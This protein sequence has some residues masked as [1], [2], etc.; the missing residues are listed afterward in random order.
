MAAR[1]DTSSRTAWESRVVL[2]S[3]FAVVFGIFVVA[4]AVLCVVIVVWAIR[5]D[6]QRWKEW[7]DH[8]GE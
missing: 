3:A 6:R 8:R 7:H 5:R 2:A 4:F 1:C